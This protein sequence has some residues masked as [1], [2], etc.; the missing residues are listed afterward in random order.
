MRSSPSVRQAATV[1]LTLAF[2]L[3]ASVLPARAQATG[4]STFPI[5][6]VLIPDSHY[7]EGCF[8]PC[9]CP[10]LFSEPAK[11]G[12]TLVF[13][14]F[15]PPFIVYDVQDINWSVPAL[16][17]TFTGSG[18]YM[19]GW[20]GTAQQQLTVDLSENGAPPVRF[21]SGLVP[22]TSTLPLIDIAIS[23]N[24][25]FCYDRGFFLKAAPARR[26]ML[27]LRVDPSNVFW[28]LFPDSP[29][30]DVVFGSLGALRS[31]GGDFRAATLGCLGSTVA[32]TPVG[33]PS[34]PPLGEAFWYLV[35]GYGG[36]AGMTYDA[37]DP[38]NGGTCDAQIDA[39]PGACP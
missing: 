3:A 35:R 36:V 5:P 26:V 7:V 9:M 12:F 24:G 37:G 16:G 32:S 11:G 25:F 28:D 15:Q 18:R 29:G 34:D 6:F 39:A 30:Y 23:V 13:S 1:A 10:V 27:G 21:D 19:I 22:V 4:S 33:G 31:T 17:K 14:G 38:G 2:I 20:K 8:G